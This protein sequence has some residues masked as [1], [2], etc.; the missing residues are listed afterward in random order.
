[1]ARLAIPSGSQQPHAKKTPSES[2]TQSRRRIVTDSGSD[3]DDQDQASRARDAD[4]T[5]DSETEEESSDSDSD[6]DSDTDTF[7][8]VLGTRTS[9]ET[10]E[11]TKTQATSDA[12]KHKQPQKP[13]QADDITSMLNSLSINKSIKSTENDKDMPNSF[14]ERV[15][16]NKDRHR[17]AART[18][19]DTK[20]NKPKHIF[21]SPE[22]SPAKNTPATKGPKHIF[23][24]PERTSNSKPSTSGATMDSPTKS[25]PQS[26]AP[27]FGQTSSLK[28][29]APKAATGMIKPRT[30]SKPIPR[31][32]Q[33]QKISTES[34][35]SLNAFQV[36]AMKMA[37]KE[38]MFAPMDPKSSQWGMRIDMD[39]LKK[40]AAAAPERQITDMS[41]LTKS[42][43][44]SK[45]GTGVLSKM[46]G[47][48]A[49]GTYGNDYAHVSPEK[50]MEGLNE[51]FDTFDNKDD[52][53]NG[54]LPYADGKVEGL[55][56]TLL[57]H[58]IRGLRFLLD[59]EAEKISHKGGLL[60]DDM[61]LGKTIQSISLIL[62]NPMKEKVENGPIKATLVVAPLALVYQWQNEIK[63]KAPK[64]RVKVHHGPKRDKDNLD[65]ASHDV[66]VTTF[67]VVSS[68]HANPGPL[69]K[70]K[71]WRIIVDEAHTIKNY[72]AKST[73]ACCSLRGERRWCL[74]GTPVQN[75]V[76]ELQSLLSF[77]EIAPFNDR[78]KWTDQI[79][80]PIGAGKGNMALK[81]LHVVLGAIMLRRTKV[82]LGESGKFKMPARKVHR[83]NVMFSE[84]E[85]K[86]YTGLEK[87]VSN[88]LETMEKNYLGALLLLLRLRQACNHLSL[89]KGEM[90][91]DLR[92]QDSLQETE[93]DA[94]SLADILGG[95]SIDE[96]KTPA[97]EENDKVE[98]SKIKELLKIISKDPTR[99]TIVFS[100]FTSMLDLIEPIFEA[101]NIKYTRYD[102]SM[103]SAKRE[104]SLDNLRSDPSCTVLLCSL[105]CGALGLNLTCASRVVLMDPWWNPM[106]SEQAIDRV[107]RL[108]QTRDVDV[109]ELI[110]MESVE[111]R[112]M[113]LQDKK[114]ELAKSIVEKGGKFVG[115]NKLSKAELFQIFRD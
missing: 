5:S 65:F 35:N 84:A 101:E 59:R 37:E 36:S 76:D 112:I 85:R 16:E 38:D 34:S 105:K 41:F 15:Q 58:Q 66:I 52:E 21:F 108:G 50:A 86:F 32:Q 39:T 2:S 103:T 79:S 77:L 60:C 87:R 82:V 49:V 106:I 74:T 73:I 17:P 62:S 13:L 56:I 102:G 8:K 96:D 33:P 99:K 61:G 110:V 63:D 6:S 57:P 22:V 51:I 78:A 111:E 95:L 31:L 68:E 70:Q 92:D 42:Q 4:T 45:S 53:A 93:Q 72:K 94:D 114:R 19:S 24:S 89:A 44:G 71:W 43:W 1:M 80:R 20:E 28:Q 83:R 91:N 48:S 113:T 10:A 69:F 25:T 9:T 29:N 14:F 7:A 90:V 54:N 81:R 46:N 23:F 107:H 18:T 26:D 12:G 98:S 115:S 11:P 27:K 100:Q 40:Q 88:S 104:A 75:S 64:L 109:Y 47:T 67:Q 55:K 30:E 97:P 3:D